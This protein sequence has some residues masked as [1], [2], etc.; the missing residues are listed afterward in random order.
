MIS[1]HFQSIFFP[2]EP[3][4]IDL[5]LDKGDKDATYSIDYTITD[6]FGK[7]VGKGM[8]DYTNPRGRRCWARVKLS[9]DDENPIG[10]F[11]TLFT[12]RDAGGKVVAT[13]VSDIAIVPPLNPNA[14]IDDSYFGV[15]DFFGSGGSAPP[16]TAVTVLPVKRLGAKWVRLMV[17]WQQMQDGPNSPV[18]WR[19]M[20]QIVNSA[21]N[22]QIRVLP[23][24]GLCPEWAVDSPETVKEIM[25]NERGDNGKALRIWAFRP[26][27]DYWERFLSEAVTRYKDRISYWEVWNEPNASSYWQD[28]DPTTYGDFF[29]ES[30]T[31]IK[32][33][34]PHAIPVM[35]GISGVKASW[36]KELGKTPAGPLID[37]VNVHPYR[38]PASPP[39]KGSPESSPGYGRN[40]LVN[41]LNAAKRMMAHFPPTL[42]GKP[43]E[44]WAGEA[45]Y[46]TLPGFPPPLHK[47]V[48]EK[49]MAKL[50]VRTMV[51]AH[52]AGA[53]K[54]FWWRLIDTYGA[55][56][57]LLRNPS[58][59]FQPKPGYAAYA[60]LERMIGQASGP[61]KRMPDES[62]NVYAIVFQRPQ[63]PVWVVWG[64]EDG[65]TWNVDAPQ[66][67][68]LTNMMGMSEYQSAQDGRVSIEVSTDPVYIEFLNEK[69]TP[70]V[71]RLP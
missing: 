4:I 57:G 55:G 53:K 43:R 41:D 13:L 18:D 32:E 64:I 35:G 6:Y 38:P 23:M 40:T 42:S 7:S 25:Q 44:L 9:F 24:M 22:A 17:G 1:P 37:I 65:M 33:A 27:K 29:A 8:V 5:L 48:S 70:S 21:V 12:V 60:V 71:D 45:G 69:D 46:N 19:M 14:P 68:R 39:E 62:G 51:L 30:Y 52:S 49:E 61:G 59:H 54:F 63:G 10:W 66:G 3:P 26:Q 47:A 50:L 15:S 67:I 56:M 20:D 2:D 36:L 31:V 16:L 34:D 28:G 58:G 11:E